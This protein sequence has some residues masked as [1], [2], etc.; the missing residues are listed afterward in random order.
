MFKNAIFWLV[1]SLTFSHGVHAAESPNFTF[2]PAD[3]NKQLSQKAIRQIYQDSTGYLWVVTQEGVS[4]Y[5]GYQLL[6]FIHDPRKPNSLSSDNVRIILEDNSKRLWLATDG[7]GLNLF[8]AAKQTFTHFQYIARSNSTP[9]SNQIRSMM[10]D[11]NGDIWLGYNSGNFSRLN[12]ET[13][14]FEHFFTRDLLPALDKNAAVT[15]IAQDEHSIWLSTDGN[16]LLKL[17]KASKNLRRFYTGSSTAIFSDRLTQVFIDVQQRLWLASY[18]A[19]ISV[20]NPQTLKFTSWQHQEEQQSSLPANLVHNI[21]QDQHQRIWIGTDAGAALWNGRDQFDTFNTTHGISDNKILSIVQDS[22]GLMWLGTFNGITKSI[23]VPFEI[24]DSGLASNSILGFA[25]TESSS[26]G[27]AIWVASYGGLTQLNS[28]GEVQQ[29]INKNSVPALRDARVMTVAGDN[30]LLWFGTRGGGLGRLNVDTNEIAFFT[31]YPDNPTSLSFNGVP[32]IFLDTFGNIWVG[33]FGGG[34]NYLAAG[35]DEFVHY[36]FD[37]NNPRS[38]NSDRVLAVYQLLD[39]TIV[40]G[41]VLG[42][43]LLDP[44]TSDFDRIEHQPDNVDSL[45]APMAWAFHQDPKGQL[46][47]GTQGG[48]INKWQAEDITALNNDFI[49][50]NSFNGLPSSH[51]YSILDDDKGHLWLSST[52]GLTRLNPKTEA[53]RNFGISEGLNDSDFSFGAGFKDSQGNMY[54]GGNSGLVRFHPD[55][56]KDSQF[57]PPVVLVRIKKLNEQVWFDVPYRKLQELVLDSTDYFVSFEFAA[58]DFKAPEQNE[59]RYKLEGLDPNWIELEHSRLATFTNLPAGDYVLKVQAS[60]NQGLWNTKGINLPIRMLPPYWRTWW[61]YSLY[62]F[63]FMLLVMNVIWRYGQR[64][65]LAIEHL[66]ELEDKVKER[67][68]ELRQANEQLGLSMQD[69][70]KA[71]ELAEQAS[72]EKSD[73]LA[74]MSHEIRTPMNGVLGMTEVLLSSNLQPKQQHIAQ[75]VYRSGRLLLDL[76]NNILDFSKLEAGK[77]T[78]ESVPV[79]LEA[80]LEDVCDL[81]SEAAYDKGLHI[82]AILCSQTLPLVYGDPAKLRQIIA[83][84][85]SNAIKFTEQGEVNLSIKRVPCHNFQVNNTHSAYQYSGFVFCVQDSGIGMAADRQQK[86]FEMF[87]QADASTTRKY[88]GTG[89]GLAICKQLTALMGGKLA[90]Q[91]EVDQGSRFILELDL[92]L[93]AAPTVPLTVIDDCPIVHLVNLDCGLGHSITTM[94]DKLRIQWL[95][96]QRIK[97]EP[98]RAK[99]GIWISL[100]EYESSVRE[101]GIPLVNWICLQATSQWQE[102]DNRNILTLPVHFS[103]LQKSLNVALCIENEPQPYVDAYYRNLQKFN[104]NILV[105]EDSMTNQEVAKSM[106]ELLGCEVWLADNG[107]EAVEHVNVQKPDLVLM[108]CQMPIMDGYAATKAIRENWPDLPIVAL[109]AA[110]GD[111][112]RQQCL[113]AGMN[114][115]MSKPFSLQ[116]LEQTLQCFLSVA[117]PAPK[118]QSITVEDTQQES[119]YVSSDS[120]SEIVLLDMATVDT[121]LRISSDTGNPVFCRV[122]DAFTQEAEKLIAQINEQVSRENLDLSVIADI[123]HAL[124]SMAGNVGAKALFELCG[125]LEDKL[126]NNQRSEIIALTQNISATFDMCCE[127]LETFR[128]VI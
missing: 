113:E 106:L 105:A 96:V 81:F 53:V 64:R 115:V 12:P 121:L 49:H 40:V 68:T 76:L 5:D 18:D 51:I 62:T 127:K 77:A 42:I 108:D 46:W 82:N 91:S 71:R 57:I 17:D 7:G 98:A 94:L 107:A 90:V 50:Y 70:Q 6:S 88:G 103:G 21:Y 1:T 45:S 109:T 110:M 89:L 100:S 11:D 27:S 63:V 48:G 102:D 85:T 92:A 120:Q 104:A 118:A 75:I 119:G 29:I 55:D 35:S 79:D 2:S 56:I 15:S 10:L 23:E 125:G 52:A 99:Q 97:S 65:L 24:I 22:S 122:L 26:D 74:I 9:M 87:T 13:M 93:S 59:Y 25:E 28:N 69:T 73:F 41:T 80:L 124:K 36:R 54:F 86:V 111:D 114:E 112:L 83:N 123:A 38:I 20:A 16:G 33:T 60:N 67:T 72:K 44:I 66:I 128:N 4:R 95:H 30:N 47:V 37:E 14:V 19:G 31:H 101:A 34:L 78:L 58:L 61:A 39:G 84:L 117:H 3:L 8:N 32:S 126:L 116:E 43:N